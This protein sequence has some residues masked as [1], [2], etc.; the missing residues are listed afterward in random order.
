M[1]EDTIHSTKNLEMAC[2]TDVIHVGSSSTLISECLAVNQKIH[3]K[4]RKE[5]NKIR[6]DYE[7]RAG[8]KPYSDRSDKKRAEFVGDIEAMMNNNASK[9]KRFVDK[10]MGVTEFRTRQVEQEK[11]RIF[12]YKKRKTNFYYRQWKTREKTALQRF[13]TNS[14][15]SSDR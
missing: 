15:I 11:S 7:G 5:L 4:I 14:S 6:S 10:D 9:S 3:Q 8:R 2:C 12:S 13:F 1:L